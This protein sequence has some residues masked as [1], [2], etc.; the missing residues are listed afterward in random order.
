MKKIVFYPMMLVIVFFISVAF[1]GLPAAQ[2]TVVPP[3]VVINEFS[4]NGAEW[5][6][7]MNTTESAI[8]FDSV[9]WSLVYSEMGPNGATTTPPISATPCAIPERSFSREKTPGETIRLFGVKRPPSVIGIWLS[10]FH[11]NCLS[12]EIYFK[13]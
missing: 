9:S 2:A 8:D 7:L 4:V 12:K 1:V 3:D 10:F 6:E 5:V 11:Y 13:I